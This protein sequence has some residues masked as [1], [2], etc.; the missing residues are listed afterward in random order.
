VQNFFDGVP[1]VAGAGAFSPLSKTGWDDSASY[2]FA[3]L[4]G[5]PAVFSILDQT[6][7]VVILGSGPETPINVSSVKVWQLPGC[8]H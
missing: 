5:S 4:P 3:T 2:T 7:L 8:A 1:S 6:H